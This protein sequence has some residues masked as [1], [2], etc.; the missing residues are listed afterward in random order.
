MKPAFHSDYPSILI[1]QWGG[2][3]AVL[4]CTSVSRRWGGDLGAICQTLPQD[5][6][7]DT[8]LLLPPRT[9]FCCIGICF[10]TFFFSWRVSSDISLSSVTLKGCFW[11]L[12]L[13]LCMWS[14]TLVSS[15]REQLT[16]SFDLSFSA[17]WD[18]PSGLEDRLGICYE[19]KQSHY[20]VFHMWRLSKVAEMMEFNSQELFIWMYKR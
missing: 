11:E 19:R 18:P 13:R 17:I 1:L 20:L 14:T 10:M 6:W 7:L 8:L 4:H 2:I 12:P 3:S 5:L 9:T 15:T 16:H